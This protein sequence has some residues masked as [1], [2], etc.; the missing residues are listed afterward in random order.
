MEIVKKF[1]LHIIK[2]SLDVR[3]NVRYHIYDIR[4]LVIATKFNYTNFDTIAN[5]LY[6]N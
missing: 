1:F 3:Y 5:T 6:E 2:L 4:N